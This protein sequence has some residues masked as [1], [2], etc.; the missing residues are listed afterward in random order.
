M[1]ITF[2]VGRKLTMVATVMVMPG[3]L[4]LLASVVLTILLMRT[5]RGQRLLIPLKRRIPPRL[6]FH[7][8]R[9]MALLTGEN[10]FLSRP[11]EL[12]SA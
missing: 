2:S 6:R 12:H 10:I 11:K 4:V 5:S 9:V 7:G 1:H 8:K 3:G